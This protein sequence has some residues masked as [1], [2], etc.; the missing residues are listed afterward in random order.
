MRY[1]QPDL[2]AM[3]W[4]SRIWLG[5]RRWVFILAAAPA[6]LFALTTTKAKPT[7]KP[8]PVVA[9]DYREL[10]HNDSFTERFGDDRPP[11][12][13]VRTI[14]IVRQLAAVEP[15]VDVADLRPEPQARPQRDAPAARRVGD[16]CSRHNMRKVMVSRYRWRC[17]R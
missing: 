6:V 3:L 5:S 9:S 8:A 14:P 2:Q 12:V 10:V 1:H 11:Q 16:I 7:H 17:R 13:R 15:A 4:H